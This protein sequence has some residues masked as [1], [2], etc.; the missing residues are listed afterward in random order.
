MDK[1]APKEY[2]HGKSKGPQHKGLRTLFFLCWYLCSCVLQEKRP[3]TEICLGGILA[4]RFSGCFF[5]FMCFFRSCFISVLKRILVGGWQKGA[6]SKSLH[7]YQGCENGV[8][9]RKRW[10]YLRDTR[11]FRHF[12]R[13]PGSEERNPLFLWVE[14]KSSFSPFFVKATC[15]R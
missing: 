14:C 8:F 10:F 3:H 12:R 4:G 7:V 5:M 11:H 13:L 2:P 1:Q 9:W 6:E 15:F